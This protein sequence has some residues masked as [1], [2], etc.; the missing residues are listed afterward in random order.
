MLSPACGHVLEGLPLRAHFS[1]TAWHQ[2]SSTHHL[3]G[4]PC[5]LSHRSLHVVLPQAREKKR[6]DGCTPPFLPHIPAPHTS[7]LAYLQPEQTIYFWEGHEGRRCV[8]GI[9]KHFFLRSDPDLNSRGTVGTCSCEVSCAL[10]AA[11]G[12]LL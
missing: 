5:H 2:H 3:K 4:Q 9:V 8:W 1:H 11:S 6:R 10:P 12:G 7:L